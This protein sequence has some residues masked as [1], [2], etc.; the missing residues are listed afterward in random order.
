MKYL[1]GLGVVILLKIMVFQNYVMNLWKENGIE[2]VSN[3]I[4]FQLSEFDFTLIKIFILLTIGII[5][6]NWLKKKF[7]HQKVAVPS[8]KSNIAML[9]KEKILLPQNVELK[10]RRRNLV[11]MTK[12][13]EKI[14]PKIL[15]GKARKLGVTS[16][17]LMLAAKIQSSTK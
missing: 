5:L 4:N 1:L 17:E 15:S 16:G 11:K 6:F 3:D 2:A 14:N 10:K 7:V 12:S 9:R 8:L 13:I